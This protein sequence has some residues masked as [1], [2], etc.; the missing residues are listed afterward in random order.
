MGAIIAL[1][2]IWM[3]MSAEAQ[4]QLR[5]QSRYSKSDV[6]RIISKLEKSSDKFRNDF[7]RALDRSRRDGSNAEDR[8]NDNIR[9]YENSLD[10]LR[11]EFNRSN[12]WWESRNQVSDVIQE[13][14]NVNS[15]MNSI[16]FRRNLERQWNSMR[17]DLNTLADT[18]DLPGLNGG[19]WNGGNNGGNNGDWNGNNNGGGQMSA[20]PSWARGTFYSTNIQG[21]TMTVNADGNVSVENNGQAT[22]GQYNRGSIYIN[23]D[24]FR[25]TKSG[26]GLTASNRN[27]TTNYSQTAPGYG[28]GDETSRPP[29]W[30]I[31]TFNSTNVQGFTMTIDNAGGVTMFSGGQT[32]YG[33]YNNGVIYINNYEYPVSRSGNGMRALDRNTGR[34]TNY[35]RQ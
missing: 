21:Y 3:P 31:G 13:A 6:S 22:Y 25:I 33:R 5:Y 32:T 18:Y 20:P 16:S 23:N 1:A 24:V 10:E 34:Y 30:A 17:T 28:G 9:D 29:N 2:A 19:G 15:M 27:Q 26:D 35:R 8:Y 7:D 12:S 4:V 14:Q 11:R